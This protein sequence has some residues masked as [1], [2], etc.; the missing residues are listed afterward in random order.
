MYRRARLQVETNAG[1]GPDIK[2]LRAAGG[3][4]AVD[5]FTAWGHVHFRRLVKTTVLPAFRSSVDKT[6]DCGLDLRL[7]KAVSGLVDSIGPTLQQ[8]VDL[9]PEESSRVAEKNLLL[10]ILHAEI[11]GAPDIEVLSR[12]N[13]GLCTLRRFARLKE[14]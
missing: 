14:Q 2:A 1:D 8:L 13:R 7:H 9:H 4:D 3:Q 10:S 12:F 6:V 11:L 5:L